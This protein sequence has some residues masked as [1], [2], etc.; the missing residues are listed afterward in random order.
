MKIVIPGLLILVGMVGLISMGISQGA[1]P[2]IGVAELMDGEF[3][4][5]KVRLQGVIDVI[6][7]DVRPMR[8]HVR[9]M[10]DREITVM[11]EVDDTRPDLFKIDTDVA[12]I[13]VFDGA[14]NTFVGTKIFTKCPSKYEAS[15][16]LGLG[17]EAARSGGYGSDQPSADPAGLDPAFQHSGEKD[18]DGVSDCTDAPPKSDECAPHSSEASESPNPLSSPE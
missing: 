4:G 9:D 15:D 10:V 3:V 6:E 5:Q 7:N 14:T 18:G 17:S 13:G 1:I 8:F 2:E 11:A 16:P 12:V